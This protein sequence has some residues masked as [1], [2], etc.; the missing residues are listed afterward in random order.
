MESLNGRLFTEHY[1]DLILV[2]LCLK[3]LL[4]RGG[5]TLTRICGKI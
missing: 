5:K 3:A 2:L 4:H 1:F